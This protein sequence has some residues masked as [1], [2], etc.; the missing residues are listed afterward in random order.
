MSRVVETGIS[1]GVCNSSLLDLP[2]AAHRVLL[3]GSERHHG[4]GG[5]NPLF[6]SGLDVADVRLQ[7]LRGKSERRGRSGSGEATMP[8]FTA[9]L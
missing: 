2:R 9:V 3:R 6:E 4:A 7:L 5:Q 8:H 1:R